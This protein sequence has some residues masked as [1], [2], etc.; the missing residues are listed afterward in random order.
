MLCNERNIA[1]TYLAFQCVIGCWGVCSDTGMPGAILSCK[2]IAIYVHG[3]SSHIIVLYK[4]VNKQVEV[5]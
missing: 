4:K 1:I 3:F 5:N 2:V